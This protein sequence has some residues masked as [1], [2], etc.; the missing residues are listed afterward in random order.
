MKRLLTNFSRNVSSLTQAVFGI[1]RRI[2]YETLSH[3]MLD[4]GQMSDLNR[5]VHSASKCMRD[6]LNYKLFGFVVQDGERIDA[7]LDPSIQELTLRKVIEKDF[8]VSGNIEIHPMDEGETRA[9]G[10]LA[11]DS[12]SLASYVISDTDYYSKLYILPGR[13][14]MKYHGDIIEIILQTLGTSLSNHMHI[15]RLRNE[16]AFDPLTNCYT[17]REFDRLIDHN[18]AIASRNDGSLSVV[19]FDID[20]FKA[21]NDTHGHPVGDRVLVEIAKKVLSSLRKSDYVARYGGE[22]FIVVFPDTGQSKAIE[23]AERLRAVVE[24]L[25]IPLPGG[26]SLHVSASF[27]VASLQ[28]NMDKTELIERADRM[29]YMA[30]DSGRNMVAPSAKLRLVRNQ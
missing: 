12:R 13:A 23:L 1:A 14:M 15:K 27:G 7:W 10:M 3:Y 16:A 18:L 5:I 6:I 4:I 29:L 24:A 19:L 2:D 20:H 21:V 8:T 11:F 9:S 28:E 17:R 26:E 22:E 25:E 30:K